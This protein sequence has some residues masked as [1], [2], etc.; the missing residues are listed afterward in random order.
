MS[1]FPVVGLPRRGR[2]RRMLTGHYTTDTSVVC[3]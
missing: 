2:H 3:S 1:R